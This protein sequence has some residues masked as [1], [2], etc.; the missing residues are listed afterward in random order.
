MD[1]KGRLDKGCLQRTEH[2]RRAKLMARYLEMA[3]TVGDH[4]MAV[5]ILQEQF[6]QLQD[7]IKLLEKEIKEDK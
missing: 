2:L 6:K 3:L 7:Q 5:A 1:D 4:D